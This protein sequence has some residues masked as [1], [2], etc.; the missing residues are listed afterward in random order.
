MKKIIAILLAL[1]MVLL[2][3]ACSGNTQPTDVQEST[4]LSKDTP[5]SNQKEKADSK[6]G[7]EPK[8]SE[9]ER[10]LKILIE[11]DPMKKVLWPDDGDSINYHDLRIKK[12]LT[13]EEKRSDKVWV[14]YIAETTVELANVSAR[15]DFTRYNEGWLLDKHEII[16]YKETPLAGPDTELMESLLADRFDYFQLETMD[17]DETSAVLSYVATKKYEYITEYYRVSELYNFG[18]GHWADIYYNEELIDQIWDIL[19]VY[20]GSF[21]T[22]DESITWYLDLKSVNYAGIDSLG[23]E[24]VRIKGA[25]IEWS[26]E[27]YQTDFDLECDMYRYSNGEPWFSHPVR[28][29]RFE[30]HASRGLTEVSDWIKVGDVYFD[31]LESYPPKE[32]VLN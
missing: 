5:R 14:N 31:K 10:L 26:K 11:K 23:R 3:I 18:G 8:I 21:N 7:K 28:Y 30:V 24:K 2:M 6:N 22:F 29:E 16:E 15:M 20:M 32:I 13:E 4:S 19:G 9:E 27:E 12:R 25:F 1:M 17:W